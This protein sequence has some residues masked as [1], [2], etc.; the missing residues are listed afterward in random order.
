MRSSPPFATRSLARAG[1]LRR[2]GVRR[3]F[4]ASSSYENNVAA[5]CVRAPSFRPCF[6]DCYQP[7]PRRVYAHVSLCLILSGPSPV[8]PFTFPPVSAHIPHPPAPS[9][10]ITILPASPWPAHAQRSTVDH[11]RGRYLQ[12]LCHHVPAC[13]CAYPHARIAQIY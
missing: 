10:T 4:F 11:V 9:L 5:R 13:I 6:P 1:R 8:T 2:A 12:H 7:G 3:A